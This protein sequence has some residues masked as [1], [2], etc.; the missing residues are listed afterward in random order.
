VNKC[1]VVAQAET[2]DLPKCAF[3]VTAVF[4]LAEEISRKSIHGRRGLRSRRSRQKLSHGKSHRD[5]HAQ[6]ASPWKRG[7][8][9]SVLSPAVE[10][11]DVIFAVLELI[12]SKF[13]QLIVSLVRASDVS[14]RSPLIMGRAN[15]RSKLFGAEEFDREDHESGD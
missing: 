14:K 2:T 4:L 13:L 1:P 10:R 5:G 8:E 6:K 11:M 15:C 12:G 3:S 7:C 9:A